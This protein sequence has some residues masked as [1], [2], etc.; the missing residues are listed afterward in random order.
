MKFAVQAAAFSPAIFV[1]RLT[2]KQDAFLDKEEATDMVLAAVA[3]YVMRA[4]DGAMQATFPKMGL[5]LEI[6]VTP[7]ATPTAVPDSKE[8]ES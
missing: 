5:T 2:K 3:Q 4:F 1:G 7:L 6:K 8:N